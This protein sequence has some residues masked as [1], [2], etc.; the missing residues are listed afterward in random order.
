ML[1]GEASGGVGG[2][3]GGGGGGGDSP[4]TDSI[5]QEN[6]KER[7]GKLRRN[8]K[9]KKIKERRKEGSKN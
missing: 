5:K 1:K 4:P 8:Q 7:E 9:I 6:N 3:G 2:G